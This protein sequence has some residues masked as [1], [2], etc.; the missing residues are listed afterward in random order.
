[1]LELVERVRRLVRTDRDAA[2]A[3]LSEVDALDGDPPRPRVLDLLPSG[4][5]RRA[6]PPRARPAGHAGRAR[7]VAGA[8]RRAD[9][10]RPRRPRRAERRRR[11]PRGPPRLHRPPHRGGAAHGPRPSCA[12]SANLLDERERAVGEAAQRRVERRLEELIDL[13]WQSDELR[14]AK[15]DVV[16]EA[17]NAVYYLDELHRNAVPDTLETLV[18]ELGRLGVDLPI[19]AR[20]LRFG[21]WIGGDRDGNPNVLPTTHAGRARAPARP[22]AARRAGGDR[23]AARRPVLVG[24]DHGRDRAARGVAGGRPRARCPSS[25]S[26]TGA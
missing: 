6:G 22:R 25:T 18:D 21:S 15:P 10:E 12:R 8:G 4:Q 14:V 2:A 9:H 7:L 3:V 24:A 5:R 19:E 1:M 23:R 16:D 17:R 13:L 26:A 20:P 11:P